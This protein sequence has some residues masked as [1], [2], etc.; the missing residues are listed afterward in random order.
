MSGSREEKYW[1]ESNREFTGFSKLRGHVFV[2]L[3]RNLLIFIL[4]IIQLYAGKYTRNLNIDNARLLFTSKY[5]TQYTTD[6]STVH[7][8]VQREAESSWT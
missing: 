8:D 4:D 5:I 1:R 7:I 6:G 2:L 3:F